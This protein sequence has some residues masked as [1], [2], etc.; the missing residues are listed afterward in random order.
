MSSSIA[1]LSSEFAKFIDGYGFFVSNRLLFSNNHANN[2]DLVD[3]NAMMIALFKKKIIITER[4]RTESFE[5]HET[6]LSVV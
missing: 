1:L 2:L 4:T 6:T 5:F 3:A